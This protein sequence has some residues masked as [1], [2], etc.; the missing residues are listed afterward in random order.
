MDLN[1]FMK[2]IHDPDISVKKMGEFLLLDKNRDGM[3]T[4]SEMYDGFVTLFGDFIPPDLI[5]EML[6]ADMKKD[7]LNG[8]NLLSYAGTQLE[9]VTD[10]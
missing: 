4:I 2:V 5:Q 8:D 1:E 6:D 7:D 9:I 10:C 3:I